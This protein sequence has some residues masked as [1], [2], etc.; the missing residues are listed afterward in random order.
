MCL[1]TIL[2]IISTFLVP[3]E[4]NVLLK[5]HFNR[6]YS[7]KMYYFANILLDIPVSVSYTHK[8]L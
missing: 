8:L 2:I 4:V 5:E 3:M 7:L 6:W 1:I